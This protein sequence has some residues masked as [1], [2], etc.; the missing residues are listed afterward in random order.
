VALPPPPPDPG[1]GTGGE[2]K[3]KRGVTPRSIGGESLDRGVTAPA[4]RHST[5]ESRGEPEAKEGG[6]RTGSGDPWSAATEVVQMGDAPDTSGDRG[7]SPPPPM[8]MEWE[9]GPERGTKRKGPATRG[10]SVVVVPLLDPKKGLGRGA[11]SK[12][13][14]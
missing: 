12:V 5:G 9:E 13:K 2:E 8:Q 10:C 11:K 14:R 3:K 1:E 4:P 6:P 7:S